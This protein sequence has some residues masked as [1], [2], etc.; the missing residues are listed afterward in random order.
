MPIYSVIKK[1]LLVISAVVS[2]N[3]N[4]RAE[5]LKFLTSYDTK[6]TF[7]D[8]ASAEVNQ[9]VEIVNKQKDIIPTSFTL[10]V[11]NIEIT[12]V[13]ATDANEK[14]NIETSE[15]GNET[16]IKALFDEQQIGIDKKNEINISYKTSDLATKMGKIYSISIPPVNE[17]DSIEDY[18]ITIQVPDN[19]GKKLFVSPTPIK[20]ETSNSNTVYYFDKNSLESGISAAFGEFQVYDFNIKY[21][22][23]NT[24]V[25]TSYQTVALPPEINRYQQVVFKNID[26]S[27]EYVTTDK[28]GN[29]IAHYK[30]APKSE[31][32]INV[33]GQVK[34][35]PF[36][37]NPNEG[38]K[39]SD[40]PQ[41]LVR[42]YTTQQKYWES[43]SQEVRNLAKSIKNPDLSVAENAKLIYR[44]VSE[45][46]KYSSETQEE[47]ISRKGARATLLGTNTLACM[48]FT[49]TFIAI[50]RAM[51]IPAREINGYAL[52]S[53]TSSTPISSEVSS[54]DFLHAWAEFYD[55]QLGWLQVDP[56]W[57]STSGLDYF[58]KLDTNHIAFV[59]KGI[60][61]E[62]P[63]PAGAYR[64]DDNEK[65]ID[66]KTDSSISDIEKLDINNIKVEVKPVL[67]FNIFKYFQGKTAYKIRNLTGRKIYSITEDRIE[68]GPLESKTIYTKK[69]SIVEFKDFSGE[70]YTFNTK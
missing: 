36:Q 29:F 18:H 33:I 41:E 62:L 64:F 63:L 61:S 59:T 1:S 40:L 19:Y 31:I 8:N 54:G 51:G 34:V 57:G 67:G 26:P 12:D 11:K 37:F 52:P 38:G 32:H 14:L 23:K 21:N 39:F 24:S 16:I 2:L 35:I 60:S 10:I 30:L 66:I 48:E 50:A 7:L 6:Y 69:D 65:Q 49:D 42:Q 43:G 27:P 70:T 13:Q 5:E 45:R 20:E 4:L 68:V 56:T 44:D 22:L 25:I 46:L 9:R 55:P 47:T 28:D 53:T 58:T 17:F 15:D 3:G